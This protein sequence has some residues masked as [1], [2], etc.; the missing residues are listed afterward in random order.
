M[1]YFLLLIT[2]SLSYCAPDDPLEKLIRAEGLVPSSREG[3]Y[4][5]QETCCWSI[6]VSKMDDEIVY[7]KPPL[8]RKRVF[9]SDLEME[10]GS[11]FGTDEGEWGGELIFEDL[12][13]KRS[14]IL[15]ES[16]VYS[17]VP[18][19]NMIFVMLGWEHMYA[20]GSILLIRDPSSPT[21]I[22]KYTE[23][24]DA[25][26]ETLIIN[27][28][29][30]VFGYDSIIQAYPIFETL[31]LDP[32]KGMRPTSA[33]QFDDDRLVVGLHG[34]MAV[35]NISESKW[36]TKVYVQPEHRL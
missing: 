15:S 21:E 11:Y 12:E 27:Q 22:E 28:S 5:Y 17:L 6:Y 29:L 32:W 16:N 34:G 23:I 8:S 36:T 3:N 14:T 25:P 30:V 31:V 4:E 13:G 9:P 20:D 10:Y 26:I 1:R 7:Q 35:V 19:G 2:I 24:G 33:V 18:W